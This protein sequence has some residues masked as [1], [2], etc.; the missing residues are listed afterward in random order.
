MNIT[1]RK[2]AD[3]E[4]VLN[5]SIAKIKN[6]A[7]DIIQCY[8]ILMLELKLIS[9]GQTSM[10][11]DPEYLSMSSEDKRD[12]IEDKINVIFPITSMSLR[13]LSNEIIT[14]VLDSARKMLEKNINLDSQLE[15]LKQLADIESIYIWCRNIVLYNV[16]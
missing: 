14:D 15:Q 12:F 2:I 16:L 10:E 8:H 1:D 3:I 4:I 5:L 7:N 11:D 6:E 13:L 9:N